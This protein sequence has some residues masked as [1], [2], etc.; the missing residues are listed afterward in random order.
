MKLFVDDVKLY[1]SF[2]HS[3]CDLQIVCDRLA[4]WAEKWQLRIAFDKCNIQRTSN[5]DGV[6]ITDCNPEYKIG[7]H[8]LHWSDEI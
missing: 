4:I 1:S 6:N 3:L 5:R 2:T 7:A 8:V